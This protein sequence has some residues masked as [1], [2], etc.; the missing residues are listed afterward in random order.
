[1]KKKPTVS[2]VIPA[3]NAERTI[4]ETVNSVL[5]QT[6]IDFELIIINDGSTDNTLD[7]LE[8]FKDPRIKVFSFENSGP[9]K[10]RNR[11]IKKAQGT[12]ISFIDADDLWK[13]D[14]LQQQL[15]TLQRNSSASVVYS[16]CD[17]IDEQSNFLRRGGYLIRRGDVFVDLL[18]INFGENGSNFMAYLD[19]V[20]AINGFDET[21][22]AGQD[23]DILLS[24]ASQYEFEVVPKVQVL[25]RKSTSK[26]SWSSSIDRTRTGIEQV[27]N[28]HSSGKL[29]L[30]IYRQQGLSNSYKHMLFECLNNHPSQR[31]G[32][33][34]LNL[35]RMIIA[36]DQKF[37]I[38]KVFVKTLARTLITIALPPKVSSTIIDWWPQLFDITSIYGYLNIDKN[39]LRPRSQNTSTVHPA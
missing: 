27:I 39:L 18:L 11:G 19:A 14:K 23:R 16:W 31:K 13:A 38:K 35:L 17:V 8:Q 24:L 9:Q 10:S 6:F 12:F 30:A 26:K 20:K 37:L 29:E 4:A 2:V 5:T 7:V 33:Y 28:K 15:E 36:N 3:Y 21:I 1:M 34:A 22:V 25:Y 32:F